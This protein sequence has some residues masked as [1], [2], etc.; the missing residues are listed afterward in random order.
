[1]SVKLRPSRSARRGSYPWVI[2]QLGALIRFQNR[3]ERL[4]TVWAVR[5][6][7][8]AGPEVRIL[9]CLTLRF[10]QV[11]RQIRRHR[12]RRL[13]TGR[14]A[15]FQIPPQPGS[16]VDRPT[17]Q[18]RQQREQVGRQLAAPFR[19]RTVVVLTPQRRATQAPLR[20]VVVHRDPRV[21]DE[22]GQPRPVL[23]QTQQHFPTR[24]TQ[25]QTRQFRARLGFHG[26]YHQGSAGGVH[27]G[28]T[29]DAQLFQPPTVVSVDLADQA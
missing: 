4:R 13:T 2:G 14:R 28:K 15:H 26:A 23:L 19:R 1:M 9:E 10:A 20:S 24:L 21:V 22:A 11:P 3:K 27:L 29:R 12:R 6:V 25:L 5:K 7:E 18:R 17:L 8:H 16:R